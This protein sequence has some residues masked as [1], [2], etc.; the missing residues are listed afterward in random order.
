MMTRSEN[1]SSPD[2][3]DD[4]GL[5]ALDGEWGP[6][7]PLSAPEAERITDRLMRQLEATSR[8][9]P[10]RGERAL[11]FGRRGRRRWPRWL[12]GAAG[13]TLAAA[14]AAL[15]GTGGSSPNREA[16]SGDR[17]APP[18]QHPTA[19]T[20]PSG[21][22]TEAPG[23]PLDGDG[24]REPRTMAHESRRAADHLARANALRGK[25]RYHEA[26]DLYLYVV[27]EY[28]DSMQSRAA[29]LAAAAIRLEQL[30]DI[31]G[32]EELYQAVLDNS[33]GELAAQAAF[34]LAEVA[35]ARADSG[36]EARALREFLAQHAGHPLAAAARRRLGALESP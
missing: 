31:D 10:T 11:A 23:S 18:A 30:R 6:S 27:S 20:D 9:H 35:R 26:L 21:R 12:L 28:P 14:A 25:R 36:A 34:G 2:E 29:Q 32:A 16:A 24:G 4:A 1:G 17:L 22:P 5:D 19:P 15:Y 33:H 8:R 7:R 3:P 13:V